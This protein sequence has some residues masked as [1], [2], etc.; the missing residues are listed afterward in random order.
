[1][2]FWL[3]VAGLVVLW[4][5]TRAQLRRAELGRFDL[6]VVGHVVDRAA[7]SEAQTGVLARTRELAS[8]GGSGKNRL[9]RL[10]DWM[11]RA[12][13]GQEQDAATEPVVAGGVPGEWV[14]APGADPKRRILYLHGGGFMVGSARSHR[15]VTSTLSRLAGAAVLSLD[16]RL[17]PENA[18]IDGITDCRNAYR[19]ILGHGPDRTGPADAV[20]VA[21]DSAGGNLTLMLAAE[22]RHE[23]L[24]PPDGAVALS[25]LA[26]STMGS[27]TW[28]SNQATDPILGPAA[29][30]LRWIPRWLLFLGMWAQQRIHPCH[31][32]VSPALGDLS[33]LPP[34]LIQ[35]S[36]AEML[37]GD[38]RRY[39]NKAQAAGS[40]VRLQTWPHMVHV[41]QLFGPDLDETREAYAE[42]AAFLDECVPRAIAAEARTAG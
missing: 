21:G 11:D 14:V 36:G 4:L 18:R 31:P 26:D 23:G 5:W 6:P 1:M 10:R 39:A 15:L 22:T 40:P 33:G 7:P 16:Y 38:A 27:P 19:F 28:Q 42:I 25:P 3:V 29:G 41:W 34:I 37:L 8:I 30:L 12:G 17:L 20:F 35:A 32:R 24:R 9:E 2:I 13:D